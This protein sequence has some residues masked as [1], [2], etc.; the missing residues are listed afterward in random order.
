MEILFYVFFQFT[1]YQKWILEFEFQK[2]RKHFATQR[3]KKSTSLRFLK[4]V[5]EVS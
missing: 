1:Y 5:F 4:Y 2:L 3:P